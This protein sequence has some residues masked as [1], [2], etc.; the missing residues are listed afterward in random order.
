MITGATLWGQTSK[1][2]SYVCDD[3]HNCG[4]RR[5]RFLRSDPKVLPLLGEEPYIGYSTLKTCIP[6][7]SCLNVDYYGTELRGPYNAFPT[8]II[9]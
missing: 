1:I 5:G 7:F 9:I 4:G 6:R 3:Y 2:A 8:S